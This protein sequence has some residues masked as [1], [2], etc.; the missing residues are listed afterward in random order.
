[1]ARWTPP[2][3]RYEEALEVLVNAAHVCNGRAQNPRRTEEDRA[4]NR[5][6][7][8]A[9]KLA[10]RRLRPDQKSFVDG[11]HGCTGKNYQHALLL[12]IVARINRQSGRN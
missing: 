6:L 2:P 4:M 9:F 10:W 8:A 5:K 11:I 12:N 7:G 1:M 3:T